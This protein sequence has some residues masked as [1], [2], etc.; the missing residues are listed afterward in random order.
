MMLFS[1]SDF[2]GFCKASYILLIQYL[3]YK[4]NTHA[5]YASFC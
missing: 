3:Q 1:I 5:I 4:Y 2:I